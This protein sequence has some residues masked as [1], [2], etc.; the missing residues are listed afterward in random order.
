M[1]FP[2]NTLLTTRE[3]YCIQ[4]SSQLADFRRKEV[5]VLLRKGL[6]R[7]ELP[8]LFF[9][10]IMV[11]LSLVLGYPTLIEGMSLLSQVK[12]K[13]G[14]TDSHRSSPLKRNGGGTKVLKKIYGTQTNRMLE[15]LS[16][17]NRALPGW[18]TSEVYGKV[19]TRRGLLLKERELINVTVLF[20]QGYQKQLFSHIRGSVR[21]GIKRG[22][23]IRILEWLGEEYDVNP[24]E[25]LDIVR[26]I[27]K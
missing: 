6:V 17:L 5:V 11:H 23:L 15:N 3:R 4:I 9:E 21:V 14:C 24:K 13:A 16:K 2:K 26:K 25:A 8:V 1:K 18:I 19:F 10:E 22:S 27:S 12:T 7:D 20:L